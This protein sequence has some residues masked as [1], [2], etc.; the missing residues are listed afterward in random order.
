MSDPSLSESDFKNKMAWVW[1]SVK[2][3]IGQPSR[4]MKNLQTQ[5]YVLEVFVHLLQRN[6]IDR[7]GK[8]VPSYDSALCDFPTLVS[9]LSDSHRIHNATFFLCA[10]SVYV[11]SKSL[12]NASHNCIRRNCIFLHYTFAYEFQANTCTCI[13]NRR[14]YI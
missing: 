9:D 10:Y 14:Y 13:Y 3:Q 1:T 6:H 12:D 8:V 11:L 4:S 5:P 7:M 2:F